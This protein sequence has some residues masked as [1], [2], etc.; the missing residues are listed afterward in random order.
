M[1]TGEGAI[2][3]QAGGTGMLSI[4][5]TW[6]ESRMNAGSAAT[7]PAAKKNQIEAQNFII[8][9]KFTIPLEKTR[10]PPVRKMAIL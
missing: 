1:R 10:A 6:T 3:P 2:V 7:A 5:S 9:L 8:A 4:E